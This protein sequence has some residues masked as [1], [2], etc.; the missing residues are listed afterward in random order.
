MNARDEAAAFGVDLALL[1]A[2][3]RLTPERRLLELDALIGLSEELQSQTLTPDQRDR[4][5]RRAMVE[6]L[7]AYGFEG[8]LPRWEALGRPDP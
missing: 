8:D 6:E 7:R 1:D 2:N 5:E 4:L 3:L